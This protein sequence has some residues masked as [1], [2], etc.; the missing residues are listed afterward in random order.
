MTTARVRS[1]SAEGPRRV[2]RGSG[3]RTLDAT[4]DDLPTARALITTL[5]DQLTTSPREIAALRHQLDVWCRRLFGKSSETVDPNQLTLALEQLANEPGGVTEPIEMDSGETPV[6]G[7]ARPRPTGVAHSRPTCRGNGSRSTS[8]TP[9][10]PMCVATRNCAWA[11]RPPRS[12]GFVER[13]LSECD[14]ASNQP[15]RVS[16]NCLCVFVPP[17][18]T[19]GRR[20]ID[21]AVTAAAAGNWRRR[22]RSV[23][24]QVHTSAPRSH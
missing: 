6:R 21:R 2:D 20:Y 15:T 14:R 13:L 12:S 4:V 16:K 23:R 24:C 19:R 18:P 17:W 22:G 11:R 5:Q 1:V 3:S 8:R 7:H 9:T 10:R